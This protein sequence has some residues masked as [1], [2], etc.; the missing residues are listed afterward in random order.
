MTGLLGRD[1]A[2]TIVVL[3]A[4]LMSAMLA[5][6]GGAIDAGRA[7]L[8]RR[9]LQSAGDAAST[10]GTYEME[11]HW[12]G[13]SFGSLAQAQ[14]ES[15]VKD[16]AGRNGWS[17]STGTISISYLQKDGS[18]SSTFTSSS[19]GVVARVTTSFPSTFG[20]IAGIAR[21]TAQTG[22]ASEFG[23][24][25][26][27]FGTVPLV[28]NKD[29][30]GSYGASKRFE[31]ANGE[32][33]EGAVNFASIVPPGCEVGDLNCYENAMQNGAS[34][35]IAVPGTYPTNSFDRSSVSDSTRSALLDRIN[36]APDETCST[37][38]TGSRRVVIAPI[39]N[40]DIG[41]STVS[42]VGFAAFFISSVDSHASAQY[43]RGCFV[44]LTAGRGTFDPN[45]SGA[46]YTGV[47]TMAIV[48]TP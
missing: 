26:Q 40:G 42:L 41:G 18:T 48:K 39:A 15:V 16:Y 25:T 4:L 29:S 33:N 37:F 22:S 35:P 43:F 44:K 34:E 1:D 31:P 45:A 28:L 9:A 47:T 19:R 6:A 24:M 12:D 10:A 36:S 23:S 32:G 11:S 38:A 14:I 30:L 3:V 17:S 2:G 8:Q 21:Y 7:D 46:G 20:K 27:A 5:G 13:T